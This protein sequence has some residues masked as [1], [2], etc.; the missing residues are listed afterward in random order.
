MNNRRCH[1]GGFTLIEVVIAITLLGVSYAAVLNAFSGSLRL[2]RQ[3]TEYQN[4]M[5]LARS[6]LDETRLD[7]RLDVRDREDEENYGG[8][9]YAYKIEVR[10]V[11]LLEEAFAEKIKLPLK[12]EAITVEVFWGKAG[13][14]KR[15]QLSRWQAR[16]ADTGKS[17][18]ANAPSAPGAPGAPGAP[19]PG[20]QAAFPMGKL[21]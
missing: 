8:V 3:A 5:L 1:S 11:P 17:A 7:T 15:Y 10:P 4:A 6:K 12:L 18:P 14:E 9:V 19:A 21:P 2:L 20:Q 16:P 13:Q